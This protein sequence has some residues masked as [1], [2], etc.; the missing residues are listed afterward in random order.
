MS[1]IK[2]FTCTNDGVYPNEWVMQP[3]IHLFTSQEE[4]CLAKF[5]GMACSTADVCKTKI[6]TASP[7]KRPTKEPTVS[8]Y[9][10]IGRSRVVEPTSFS[11]WHSH[12]SFLLPF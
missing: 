6:P 5:P 12:D 7:T 9:Q 4:C 2:L 1:T 11:H 10:T 3:D 8:Y